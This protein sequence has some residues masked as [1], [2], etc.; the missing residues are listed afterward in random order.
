[1]PAI[2]TLRR[3]ILTHPQL[4]DKLTIEKGPNEGQLN[5]YRM[6][7]LVTCL[8]EAG[9]YVGASALQLHHIL[10]HTRKKDAIYRRQMKYAMERTQLRV[11]RE[12]ISDFRKKYMD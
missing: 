11:L 3:T 6:M 12:I 7:Y 4:N 8:L 10:E 9:I 2:T 5:R 1:M